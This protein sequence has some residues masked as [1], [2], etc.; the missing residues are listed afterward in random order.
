MVYFWAD[1]ILI[2][3][4][5]MQEKSNLSHVSGRFYLLV[6]ILTM[7]ICGSI[8]YAANRHYALQTM[9]EKRHVPDNAIL[10]I[11]AYFKP[12]FTPVEHFIAPVMPLMHILITI[13]LIEMAGKLIYLFSPKIVKNFTIK[14]KEKLGDT[15]VDKIKKWIVEP[16]KRKKKT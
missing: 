14:T 1:T 15:I 6:A 16:L 8:F 10:N 4:E 5:Q 7:L 3:N 13:G 12:Y 9:I 2:K 11:L